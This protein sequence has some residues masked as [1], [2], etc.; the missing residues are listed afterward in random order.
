[1]KQ[2]NKRGTVESELAQ[3]LRD[4]IV[5]KGLTHTHVA[6]QIK[7]SPHTITRWLTGQQSMKLDTWDKIQ[8]YINNYEA[9]T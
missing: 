2:T 5:D 6:K 3:Q 8:T 9:N 7:C 1:M 4:F